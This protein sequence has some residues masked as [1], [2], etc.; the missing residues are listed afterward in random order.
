MAGPGGREADRVSVRV[1]PDTSRFAADLRRAL[2]RI[3]SA[4]RV[5][6]RVDA[7]LDGFTTDV[8]ARLAALR[9]ETVRVRVDAD[10][11][12]L[13]GLRSSLTALGRDSGSAGGPLGSLARSVASVRT[14]ALTAVPN[15]AGLA[16]GLVQMA[17]AAG[18]AA[19]GLLAV[20]SASA[21]VKIGTA[22]VGD[23]L[24]GDADAMARLAPSARSFVTEVQSLKPAWDGLRSSVQQSLF[25]GLA[26]SVQRLGTSVLPVLRAQLTDTAGALNTMG[27]GAADAAADLADSGTLG[28][29]MSSANTGLRNLAGVP[30]LVVRGLGQ[31]AAAAGPSFERITSGAA[32]AAEGVSERLNKAFESGGLQ[33]AIERAVSLVGQL[34]STL[35]NLGTAVGN[36]FGPAADAGAGF[37]GVLRDVSQTLAEVTGT[38]EAQAAFQGLFDALAAAGQ[39]ISG[40]LG[41]ALRAALPLIST[42]VSALAGPLQQAFAT[43]GPALETLVSAL[44]GALAPVVSAV[45]GVLAD[46]VPIAAEIVTMLADALAPVLSS[47][48]PVIAR[49]VTVLGTA[50]QPILAQLPALLAPFLALITRLAPILVQL[51]AQ[52]ISALAPALMQIG[53]AFGQLLVALAPLLAAFGQLMGDVLLA[54]VP[55]LTPIIGLVAQLAAIFAGVLA[56]AVTNIL[57]PALRL[58]TDLLRGDFSGAWTHAKQLLAGVGRFFRQLF[59]S[60]GKWAADGIAAVVSW[61]LGLPGR[62]AAAIAQFG[63]VLRN[64]AVNGLARM[65]AG[66]REKWSDVK[67]WFTAL[68]GRAKQALGDLGNILKEAGKALLRGFINGIKSMFGGVKKTLSG[69]TDMLPDIKGPPK[70]DARILRP[71]GRLVMAGFMD[72]ISAAVPDLRAQLRAV[73]DEVAGY[74][75]AIAAQVET[76]RAAWTTDEPGGRGPT[77]SIGTFVANQQQTP[78]GIAR[79]LAWLAKG[80]G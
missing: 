68:P 56:S 28:K 64:A 40:V 35:A 75:P 7:D 27:K 23:A 34:F 8:R 25:D 49:L 80:R 46:L 77:V 10:R 31:I 9:D 47:L 2:D 66:L 33:R 67:A 20:A 60:F 1:V 70:R 74:R 50:L 19:T 72:G 36:I 57:V 4:L 39:V 58:I 18:V 76:S 15:I 17:P 51:A 26:G 69:L 61:L 52:I 22:G 55:I 79:E 53:A 21:A 73:T 3:E 37:L 13:D 44:G 59:V 71:A 45:A 14:V 32:S 43:I 11:D 62:A 48:G 30:A 5:N 54:L 41:A 65:L 63:P 42:L 78:A 16:G 24:K 38:K 6:V 29:A 12:G